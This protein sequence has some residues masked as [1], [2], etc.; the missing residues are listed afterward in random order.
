[1]PRWGVR[2]PS[3]ET[4]TDDALGLRIGKLPIFGKIVWSRVA[5]VERGNFSG[6][7]AGLGEFKCKL[8][9]RGAKQGYSICRRKRNNTNDDTWHKR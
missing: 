4:V 5:F 3:R 2:Q 8:R 1:L 9:S 7:L 6:T